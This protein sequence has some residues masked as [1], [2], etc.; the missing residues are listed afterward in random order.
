MLNHATWG[1]KQKQKQKT[2]IVW[3]LSLEMF[4]NRL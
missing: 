2:W 3:D 1:K 4:D